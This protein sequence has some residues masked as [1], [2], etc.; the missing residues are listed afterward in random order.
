MKNI[1]LLGATGGTGRYLVEDLLSH[2]DLNAYH[3]I[4]AGTRADGGFASDAIE[5]VRVDISAPSSFR[6]LPEQAYCVVDLA[7]IMPARME[8]YHPQKYI[9][10]NISGTLNVLEYCRRAGA[11]RILYAQ[12][13]GDIQGLGR[14]KAGL[15][16]GYATKVSF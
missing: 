5:Y 11:D 10:V 15:N 1:I 13:F 14:G 12:S 6:A 16:A 2:L 3:I 8:G 9:D 7:G 4:A